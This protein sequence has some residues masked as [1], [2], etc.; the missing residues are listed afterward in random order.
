MGDNNDTQLVN[1]VRDFEFGFTK[2]GKPTVIHGGFE[3]W[4]HRQNHVGQVTWRCCQ[5][6]SMKCPA[7]IKTAG[8]H[9][10]SIPAQHTHEG[11][12]ATSRARAAVH[13]MKQK[14]TENAATPS[15]AQASVVAQLSSEVKMALPDRNVVARNLRRYREACNKTAPAVLPPLPTGINFD[16]PTRYREMVVRD[17]DADSDSRILILGEQNLID[18]LRRSKVWLADGTFKKCPTLFFQIYA[19]HYEFANGINPVGLI[20]LLPNK[21]GDTYRRLLDA[22]KDLLPDAEPDFILTDFEIAAMDAFRVT[23]PNSTVTGC[24]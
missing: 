5:F 9:V 13:Q 19:I 17:L 15:A 3:Y 14:M 24:Y 16:V 2:R 23:Y 6:Q 8:S 4:R 20:C 21:T 11:N 1:T 22:V 12:V 10:I 7:K 18:G